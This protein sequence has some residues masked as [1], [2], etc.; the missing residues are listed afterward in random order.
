M[1][2]DR[3][4]DGNPGILT[5]CGIVEDNQQHF[6]GEAPELLSESWRQ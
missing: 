4:S 5:S 1:F 2:D 6:P 3:R